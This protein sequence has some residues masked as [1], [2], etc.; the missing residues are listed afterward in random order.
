MA[1]IRLS[2]DVEA[3]AQRVS[4]QRGLGSTRVAIEAIVRTCWQHYLT[5]HGSMNPPSLP[6]QPLRVVPDQPFDAAAELDAVL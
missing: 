6:V 2:K 3:I 5:G 4:D 1:N